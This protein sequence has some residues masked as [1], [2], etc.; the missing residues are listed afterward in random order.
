MSSS[1]EIE[2]I[3]EDPFALNSKNIKMDLLLF[4]DEILKDIKDMKKNIT[5]KL[6]N[7]NKILNEKLESYDEKFDLYNEKILQLNKLIVEDK[8]I[9][10]KVDKLM[11]AKLT[12]KDNILTH[13]IKLNHIEKDFNT[14]IT[15]IN[16][17]LSESVIYPNVIGGI[18]KIK[19]FHEFIDY[20]LTQISQT[21]SFKEKNTSN[22]NSYKTKIENLIKSL[23]FQLDNLVKSNNEY[24]TKSVNESEEKIKNIFLLY[25]EKIKNV[26][27]ENQN[28]ASSLEQLYKDMKEELK[29]F[30]NIKNNIYNKF[31][32]DLYNMKKDNYQVVKMF[33]NY[34]NEFNLLK[35]RFTKLSEFIKDIR[36]RKNLG[37]DVKKKYFV[38]IA[39]KIDFSKNN[40]DIS[41]GIK[42]YIHGEIKADEVKIMKRLSK[43]NI[44][45]NP[46]NES[47][48]S[49]ED[50]ICSNLKNNN[51]SFGNDFPN[52]ENKD[53][54]NLKSSMMKNTMELSNSIK[55]RTSVYNLLNPI[56]F[57]EYKSNSPKKNILLDN[58]V[59]KNNYSNGDIK[60][61][62]SN[63]KTGIFGLRSCQSSDIKGRKRYA[64]FISN[65]NIIFQLKNKINTLKPINIDCEIN[66]NNEKKDNN[67]KGII[68]EEDEM[69]CNLSQSSKTI[70]S[71]KNISKIDKN[72]IY[73]EEQI[74][75]NENNN[76]MYNKIVPI[77]IKRT[78]KNDNINKDLLSLK[79]DLNTDKS[80][81]S[82][83]NNTSIDFNKN[84]IN[85][86]NINEGNNK[87]VHKKNH[88]KEIK[89]LKDNNSK[90]DT[91]QIKYE[92]YNHSNE[93]DSNKKKINFNNNKN[94]SH[95]T[96][97]IKKILNNDYF[98][99]KDIENLVINKTALNDNNINEE[100]FSKTSY[101]FR[102]KKENNNNYFTKINN[103]TNTCNDLKNID[104]R[105]SFK[106]KKYINISNSIVMKIK[107][108]IL[109]YDSH[110][111]I[112]NSNK[113]KNLKKGKNRNN[114]NIIIFNSDE[115][116][117]R[118]GRNFFSING[119]ERNLEAKNIEK[120]VNNL[121]SYIIDYNN[122]LNE[123]NSA[124][125][126]SYKNRKNNIF[127]ETNNSNNLHYIGNN[128]YLGNNSNKSKD[129]IAK[130][131]LK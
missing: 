72:D 55:K 7:T 125:N 9:K 97:K 32:N 45:F 67:K 12:F 85:D 113:I 17:I 90:G 81:H 87:K 25:D 60:N 65:D 58:N 105:N 42:K 108:N 35:D 59:N 53:Y 48:I 5:D 61:I 26:R 107:G 20:V 124:R 28:Y 127:K 1:N 70:S 100:V 92:N 56:S 40:Y 14:K 31:N 84:K 8:N 30:N 71:N 50:L 76:K 112:N 110:T 16:G 73:K 116:N 51:T 34:K 115:E 22:L 37:S 98:K 6:N 44:N 80:H 88:N 64:S 66:N 89:E 29:K 63:I 15:Q 99:S 78:P 131:K 93:N 21:N 79:N 118:T 129:Y 128:S 122:N 54:N 2:K 69:N 11:E 82:Q 27:V 120:M 103:N 4:K 62:D 33:G 130:L 46:E 13:D 41:S 36:F 10:D 18:S 101:N 109:P 123:V 106:G 114:N 86:T 102:T 24:T 74:I 95:K 75:N 126:S 52:K 104:K 117:S 119:R 39:N 43:A 121:R 23:Q 38:E 49:N 83:M 91:N 68:K 77:K 111:N 94:S 47:Y 19:T 96:I 57:K 3:K